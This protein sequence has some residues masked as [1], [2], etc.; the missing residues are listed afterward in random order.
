IEPLRRVNSDR[1]SALPMRLRL[2][3][4][5]GATIFGA[6]VAMSLLIAVLG[7]YGLFVLQSAGGFVVELYDRPLMAINFGRAASLDF[8]EMDKELIRRGTASRQ[9]QAAIDAKIAH[10]P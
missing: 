7:G 2:R 10:L 3:A 4:S 8:A 6:F 1:E 5:I 9:D